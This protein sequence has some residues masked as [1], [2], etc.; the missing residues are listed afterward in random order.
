[1]EKHG[2]YQSQS[3][4][5]TV[6]SAVFFLARPDKQVRSEFQATMERLL[7][8]TTPVTLHSESG[9]PVGVTARPRKALRLATASVP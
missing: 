8:T 9:P 5:V 6:M 4:Q 2:D 7:T 1:M 3:C